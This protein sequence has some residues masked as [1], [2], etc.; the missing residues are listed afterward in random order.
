MA[1]TGKGQNRRGRRDGRYGGL[2][3]EDVAQV[4]SAVPIDMGAFLPV[5]GKVT[6]TMPEN[7]DGGPEGPPVRTVFWLTAYDEQHFKVTVEHS[8]TEDGR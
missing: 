1:G 4:L 3:T 2:T 7:E 5:M 6:G 8:D